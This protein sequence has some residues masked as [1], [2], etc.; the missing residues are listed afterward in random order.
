MRTGSIWTLIGSIPRFRWHQSSGCERLYGILGQAI[1]NMAESILQHENAD[2]SRKH[3]DYPYMLD[4]YFDKL[5]V[6]ANESSLSS[7]RRVSIDFV[8]D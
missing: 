8:E 6:Y 2:T 7:L 1:S 5:Q 3:G 4:G